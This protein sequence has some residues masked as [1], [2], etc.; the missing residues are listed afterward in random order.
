MVFMPVV[1][2]IPM[3]TITV[4]GADPTIRAILV[5]VVIYIHQELS[6]VKYTCFWLNKGFQNNS[7][8]T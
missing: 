5:V 4:G 2:T 1:L 7:N 8:T 6:N 3:V